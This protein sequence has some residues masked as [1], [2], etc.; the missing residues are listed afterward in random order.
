MA[1]TEPLVVVLV[2]AECSTIPEMVALVN[3]KVSHEVPG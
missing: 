3:G 1:V 2:S